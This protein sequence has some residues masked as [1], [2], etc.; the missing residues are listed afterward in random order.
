MGI[1]QTDRQTNKQ[2]NKRKEAESNRNTINILRN[3]P[4]RTTTNNNDTD[5]LPIVPTEFGHYEDDPQYHII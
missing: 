3:I 1:E 4:P 5:L 2:T